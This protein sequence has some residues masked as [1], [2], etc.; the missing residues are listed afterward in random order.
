MLYAD[1]YLTEEEF[2]QMF[3]HTLYNK[4]RLL[5]AADNNYNNK[6]TNSLPQGSK[7]VQVG[8]GVS[9]HLF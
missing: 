8:A 5:F 6:Q 2:H 9:N 4:V 3:D 7:Q 1:T